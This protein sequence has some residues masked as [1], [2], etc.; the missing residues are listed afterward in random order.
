MTAFFVSSP[1]IPSIPTCLG[2]CLPNNSPY[3]NAVRSVWSSIT[4]APFSPF[5]IVFDLGSHVT[6]GVGIG[7]GFVMVI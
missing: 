4:F 7:D 3:P 6:V 5:C 2:P 1:K